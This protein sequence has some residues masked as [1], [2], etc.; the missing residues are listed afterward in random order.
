MQRH[1]HITICI[2]SAPPN[3]CRGSHVL[4]PEQEI[5][6]IFNGRAIALALELQTFHHIDGEGILH[7][8]DGDGQRFSLRMSR[9]RFCSVRERVSGLKLLAWSIG[10]DVSSSV[11]SHRQFALFGSLHDD[12]ISHTVHGQH[13]MV[14]VELDGGGRRNVD[15]PAE[16][17]QP[18]DRGH[19]SFVAFG[20]ELRL[21]VQRHLQ[22]PHVHHE[23]GEIQADLVGEAEEPLILLLRLRGGE[24]GGVRVP[25]DFVGFEDA[26]RHRYAP[27]VDELDPEVETL[28]DAHVSVGLEFGEG[29]QGFPHD[30][31]GG[32]GPVGFGIQRPGAVDGKYVDG[33]F[34]VAAK[35]PPTSLMIMP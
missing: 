11:G 25:V 12:G 2:I 17:R 10:P 33:D 5:E 23:L 9:A 19:P 16:S 13:E 35:C 20:G 27:A 18:R 24:S 30:R 32:P 14:H 4:I 26:P 15:R 6:G 8:L 7:N 31:G 29:G 1:L 22:P 3:P 21:R 34:R 28:P